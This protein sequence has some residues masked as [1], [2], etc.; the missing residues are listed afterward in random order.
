MQSAVKHHRPHLYDSCQVL[1]LAF[2]NVSLLFALEMRGE[3]TRVS[4]QCIVY[5]M[6]GPLTLWPI[7]VLT[8]HR[9]VPNAS[10]SFWDSVYDVLQ[11][12]LD[13][14]GRNCLHAVQPLSKT[15]IACTKVLCAEPKSDRHVS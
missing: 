3:A 8:W 14:S 15:N 7:K 1:N 9:V 12:L 10:T 13:L 5:S 4:P 11:W 2:M 6:F